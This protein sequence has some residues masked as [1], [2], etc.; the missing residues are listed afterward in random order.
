MT[1]SVESWHFLNILGNSDQLYVDRVMFVSQ[2][3]N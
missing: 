1:I 2:I 3:I